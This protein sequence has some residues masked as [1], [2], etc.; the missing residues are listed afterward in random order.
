MAPI[1]FVMLCALEELVVVRVCMRVSCFIVADV[2]DESLE[3][4]LL[5]S[6]VLGIGCVLMLGLAR[7]KLGL[8]L[9]SVM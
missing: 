9:L 1:V 8:S 4:V 2:V 3:L 7:L 5:T 6:L